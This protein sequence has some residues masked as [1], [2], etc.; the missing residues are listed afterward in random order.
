MNQKKHE[1]KTPN[2]GSMN[3]QILFILLNRKKTKQK[4]NK[5][6]AFVL[7][8]SASRFQKT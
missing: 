1:N 8:S 7:Y 5:T 4:S 6:V 2:K 3:H